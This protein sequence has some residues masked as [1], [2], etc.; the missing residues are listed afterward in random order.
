[1]IRSL[2]GLSLG[3]A[4]F[5]SAANARADEIKR[6]LFVLGIEMGGAEGVAVKFVGEPIEKHPGAIALI[7]RNLKWS[8]DV[9]DTLKLA[10]SDGLKKLLADVDA[11]KSSFA[12]MSKRMMDLRLAMQD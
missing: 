7:K 4:M 6:A 9:A 12:D 1:M 8:I 10:P 5:L 2:L 3:F 11:N